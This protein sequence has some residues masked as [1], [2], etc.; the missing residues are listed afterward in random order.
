MK[1]NVGF[2]DLV[3]AN[4]TPNT[5]VYSHPFAPG[6]VIAGRLAFSR[7]KIPEPLEKYVGQTGK[8]AHACKGKKGYAFVVCLREKSKEM[9]ITKGAR[10]TRR[11]KK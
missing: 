8:V 2:E 6:K 10:V 5:R 3:T 9:G 7:Y 11:K 1:I 4:E